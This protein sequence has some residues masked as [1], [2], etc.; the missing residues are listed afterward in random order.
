MVP[1]MLGQESP[2]VVVVPYFWSDQY[3]L[4]IQCLGEPGPR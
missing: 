1:A 4:K 2:A 3:D